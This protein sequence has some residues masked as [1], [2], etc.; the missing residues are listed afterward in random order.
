MKVARDTGPA[1]KSA[2]IAI[3]GGGLSGLYA[4]WRLQRLGLHDWVLLEARPRL[5]GRIL[6]ADAEGRRLDG[7]DRPAA[8]GSDS[9]DRFDLG[10]AWFWPGVQQAFGALVQALGL[11]CFEQPEDGDMVVERSSRE[12]PLRMRGYQSAPPS[13]RL[14]G[15]MA[16]LIEA[17]RRPLP[18]GRL[19]TGCAVQ[20]LHAEGST[21]TVAAASGAEGSPTSWQVEHV[22]LA[23]PPRLAVQRIHATPPWP[24]A[25]AQTWQ[26]TETWMAPHA[27]Y[28][29]VYDTPFWRAQ[30]LSGAARSAVGP[31]VEIH[32][33]S[34]P[35]GHAA[36]FGFVGVPARARCSVGDEVLKAQ[37]RAQLARLFGPQALTPRADVLQDWAADP[38]TAT[39]ADLGASGRHPQ[40]PATGA[41][42]GPW[43]GR[44][45]GIGS[46]WSHQFPGY[47]AG[48]VE[49]AEAGVQAFVQRAR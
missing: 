24:P 1:M 37:G 10:P 6:V 17:L 32:D 48:A 43:R 13:M 20:R 19:I 12:P 46:E 23:L 9:L 35:G 44:L 38:D 15:G 49:A 28:L 5:G 14:A 21:I 2:R 27:K 30:G 47:L 22:L 45:T 34:A 42:E 26:A 40:P 39:E 36:L 18:V 25:L 16:A 31:L 7:P 41:A 29:A 3:V 11:P 8:S 4:A 33:A